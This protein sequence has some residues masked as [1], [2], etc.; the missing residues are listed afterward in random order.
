MFYRLLIILIFLFRLNL[1]NICAQIIKHD[2]ISKMY[3]FMVP[4]GVVFEPTAFRTDKKK[5]FWGGIKFG[6]EFFTTD[7]FKH[8]R[9]AFSQKHRLSCTKVI[10]KDFY[11]NN[12]QDFSTVVFGYQFNCG[13]TIILNKNLNDCFFNYKNTMSAN[14]HSISILLGIKTEIGDINLSQDM[15][16]TFPT[17]ILA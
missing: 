13:P 10:A 7:F 6:G 1:Y 17:K 3:R 8:K 9:I 5:D 15:S 11:K 12:K 4:V 2:Y 16:N 14:I